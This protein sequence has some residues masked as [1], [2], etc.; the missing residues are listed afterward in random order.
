MII[1]MGRRIGFFSVVLSLNFEEFFFFDL[2]IETD[3]YDGRDM[4]VLNY[5]ISESTSKRRLYT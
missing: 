1:R 4:P 3:L 2:F 5:I